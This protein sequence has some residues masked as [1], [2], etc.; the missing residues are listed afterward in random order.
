DVTQRAEK[1]GYRGFGL[2]SG[3]QPALLPENALHLRRGDFLPVFD[4]QGVFCGRLVEKAPLLV[5]NFPHADYSAHRYLRQWAGLVVGRCQGTP[6]IAVLLCCIVHERY[7]PRDWPQNQEPGRRKSWC[8]HLLAAVG[9][10][11]SNVVVVAC[12]ARY[13]VTCHGGGISCRLRSASLRT[14]HGYFPV[15]LHPCRAV[16]KKH[17]P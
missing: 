13:L 3:N 14:T 8:R 17:S 15:V 10:K 11:K 6:R 9:S 7:C 2:T 1:C 12:I 4:G 16:R 5:C